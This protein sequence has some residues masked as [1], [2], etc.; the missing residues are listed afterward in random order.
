MLFGQSDDVSFTDQLLPACHHIE[1]DTK[2]LALG[3]NTVK[4]FIGKADLVAI[5]C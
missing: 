1:E 3:Y 5:F 2:L 4:I